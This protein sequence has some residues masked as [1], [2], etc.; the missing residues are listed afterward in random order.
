MHTCPSS[1]ISLAVE[2]RSGLC[3][4]CQKGNRGSP[5]PSRRSSRPLLK[6]LRRQGERFADEVAMIRNRGPHGGIALLPSDN[7][8]S[9]RQALFHFQGL[10]EPPPVPALVGWEIG[11]A[12]VPG[13]PVQIGVPALKHMNGPDHP[14]LLF[15]MAVGQQQPSPNNPKA[16]TG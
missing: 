4:R 16:T 8:A 7:H 5:G 12:L 15:S 9:R 10:D 13:N 6:K 1:M 3:D 2:D 14:T 11:S